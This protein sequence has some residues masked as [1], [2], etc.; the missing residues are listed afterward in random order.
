VPVWQLKTTRTF[1]S[2]EDWQ[3]ICF[4]SGH[5]VSDFPSKGQ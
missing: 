5:L 2:S 4:A 1:S 3:I